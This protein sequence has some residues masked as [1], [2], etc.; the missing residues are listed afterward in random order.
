MA[1]VK[2]LDHLTT[3]TLKFLTMTLTTECRPKGQ[4]IVVTLPPLIFLI[5]VVIGML[6]EP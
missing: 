4:K 6:I 1:M 2:I 3:K 5:L